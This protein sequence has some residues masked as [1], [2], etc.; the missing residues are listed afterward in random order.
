MAYE[1]ILIRWEC[2]EPMALSLFKE[3]V[4][5]RKVVFKT[6][7]FINK[8]V[9]KKRN[10]SQSFSMFIVWKTMQVQESVGRSYAKPTRTKFCINVRVGQ[11]ILLQV[12]KSLSI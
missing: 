9:R 10:N 1:Q 6:L 5:A 3:E 2:D 4:T 11:K 7:I 12:E 8:E